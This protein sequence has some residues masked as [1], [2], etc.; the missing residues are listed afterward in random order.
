MEYTAGAFE[1]LL[2]FLYLAP[3]GIVKFS[4]DGSVDLINPAATGLLLPLLPEGDLAN[5][6]DSLL[7][8][9]PDLRQRI[10]AFA[11]NAGTV[12]SQQRLEVRAGEKVLELSL[13]VQRVN[14]AVYM[15][16]LEDVTESAK[17]ERKVAQDQLRFRAIFDNIR[18]YAIYTITLQGL[19]EE[20]NHSLERFGGWNSGDVE[21]RNIAMFFQADAGSLAQI[22]A[23][24]ASARALGSVETEGWLT[25]RDGSRLW[26]NVIITAIPDDTG[27]ARGFVVVAR[28]MT[29]RKQMEDDLQQLAIVDPLTGAFNRRHGSTCLRLE[30]ERMSRTGQSLAVLMIDIDWFKSINDTY[31][32]ESGDAVLCAMVR[33][34]KSTLRVLDTFARWGGEEFFVVLP[35]TDAA[36]ASVTAERLRANVAALRVAVGNNRD[37]ALTVSVGVAVAVNADPGDLLRRVDGALYSAKTAG[38]N[39]IAL[40]PDSSAPP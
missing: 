27:T 21:G 31:G 19:I 36:G 13:T 23:L 8:L 40:A 28:D 14:D 29:Q 3:I 39:R 7:P 24:L 25:N 22:D 15:A 26:G 38:R 32:H 6:Y 30:F 4:Y 10:R 5:L 16:V 9:V 17:H 37:V 20:W 35:G 34:C 18:D 33:A 2:Q 12:L 1:E 11:R